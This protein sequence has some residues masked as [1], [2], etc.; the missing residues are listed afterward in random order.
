VKPG[1][2]VGKGDCVCIVEA[3]KLY[4]EIESPFE[5]TVKEIR[6]SAGNPVMAGDVIVVL[7]AGN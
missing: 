3:M 4:N 6:A 7:D 2:K 1:E 5:G